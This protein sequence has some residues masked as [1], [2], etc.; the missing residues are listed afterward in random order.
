MANGEF[1]WPFPQTEGRQR[2]LNTVASDPNMGL[3]ARPVR[4]QPQS[5]VTQVGDY[6]N[7]WLGNIGTANRVKDAES[8]N[9]AAK[10]SGTA[11]EGFQTIVSTYGQ[12]P[13]PFETM[14][15]EFLG[16]LGLKVSSV[17]P[18]SVPGRPV[19]PATT[20][21]QYANNIDK[22]IKKVVSAG[23]DWLAEQVKGYFNVAY[24]GPVEPV[25]DHRGRTTEEIREEWTKESDA[26]Q[27]YLR[28]LPPAGT[29]NKTA[30]IILVIAY[31]LLVA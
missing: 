7:N 22:S 24:A 14:A 1:Q 6:I 19:A 12:T 16:Q 4:Y 9:I 28:G 25:T 13:S 26:Y 27:E 20:N 15:D 2:D 23:G 8:L 3:L 30:L 11:S 31:L 17:E 18:A 21:Y 10:V 29:N 5:M